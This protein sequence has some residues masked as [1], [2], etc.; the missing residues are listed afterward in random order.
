MGVLK[1]SFFDSYQEDT[2]AEDRAVMD[3]FVTEYFIDFHPQA[4]CIRVGFTADAAALQ[5][6]ELIASTYVQRKIAERM[7]ANVDSKQEIENDKALIIN[8]LRQAM[9]HGQYSSRVTAAD[10]L[11]KM[12]GFM[13]AD[14]NDAAQ[15]LT[16]VFKLVAQNV[17]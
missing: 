14:G 5:S 11:A 4:A 17:K 7:R 15:A 16:D 1:V 3:A 6:K 10:R 12:R 2:T 9:H 8:A 13:E